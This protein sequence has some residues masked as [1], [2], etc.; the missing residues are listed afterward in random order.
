MTVL[1]ESG[2]L[3]LL[4]EDIEKAGELSNWARKHGLNRTAISKVIHGHREPP[5]LKRSDWKRFTDVAS[6]D[7]MV[8]GFRSS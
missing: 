4:K 5:F 1:D 8:A 3:R 7:P 2:V 6:Q